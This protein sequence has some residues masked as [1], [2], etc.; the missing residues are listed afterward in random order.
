MKP[1]AFLA[2]FLFCLTVVTAIAT[3][4]AFELLLAGAICGILLLDPSSL[5]SQL[6]S[7]FI[8]ALENETIVWIIL[9]CGMP[10]G[11]LSSGRRRVLTKSE[12]HIAAL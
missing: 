8:N 12:K 10:D 3:K 2:C 4:R 7:I 11:F 1:S 6:G 5:F 9:V